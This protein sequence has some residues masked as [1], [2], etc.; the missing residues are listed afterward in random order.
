MK[1]IKKIHINIYPIW[2]CFQV[3]MNFFLSTLSSQEMFKMC[4]NVYKDKF[5][6]W[7]SYS[8]YFSRYY[9]CFIVSFNNFA[10]YFKLLYYQ[11]A[12]CIRWT[13][14]KFVNNV[15]SRSFLSFN[16]IMVN[17]YEKKLSFDLDNDCQDH[18]IE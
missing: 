8:L 3:K 1:T 2:P 10:N 17:I 14:I 11:W 12:F 5:H 13:D 16:R 4:L 7:L 9:L 6:H 15:I 18:Y